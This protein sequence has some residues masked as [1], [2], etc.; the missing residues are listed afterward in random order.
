M[1]QGSHAERYI[2]MKNK[3]IYISI[4]LYTYLCAYACVDMYAKPIYNICVY[5]DIYIYEC[6]HKYVLYNLLWEYKQGHSFLSYII[7][8][9]SYIRMHWYHLLTI[10]DILSSQCSHWRHQS[11]ALIQL[12]QLRLAVN[13]SDPP[14]QSFFTFRWAIINIPVREYIYFS[15][16]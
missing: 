13:H 4:Y 6:M 16:T 1:R 2:L 15:T 5:I 9:C 8:T 3:Y 7:N 14:E 11:P 10:Y 12:G